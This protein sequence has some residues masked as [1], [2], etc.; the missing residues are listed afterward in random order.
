ML[1]GFCLLAGIAAVGACFVPKERLLAWKKGAIEWLEPGMAV[2]D[3]LPEKLRPEWLPQSKFGIDGGV[4]EKGQPKEK[5]NAFE[6]LDK[7]EGDVGN[8][9]GTADK[10]FK[11]LNNFRVPAGPEARLPLREGAFQRDM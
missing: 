6:D 7:L 10:Q 4:D 2:L 1:I 5:M 9:R 11:E 8:M 3:Y